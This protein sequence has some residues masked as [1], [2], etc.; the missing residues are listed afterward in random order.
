MSRFLLWFGVFLTACVRACAG[1]ALN[2]IDKFMPCFA[3][4]DGST[5]ANLRKDQSRPKTKR[6]KFDAK[7]TLPFGAPSQKS[8][9]K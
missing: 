4:F 9:K 2:R 3:I 1:F 5:H 6:A 8:H 7:F